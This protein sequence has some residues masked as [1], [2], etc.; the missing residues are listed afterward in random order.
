MLTSSFDLDLIHVPPCLISHFI[1]LLEILF[2]IFHPKFISYRTLRSPTIRSNPSSCIIICFPTHF[3]L[4][5]N[6]NAHTN[7]IVFPDCCSSSELN[8]CCYQDPKFQICCV[9]HFELSM[10]G[11]LGW[12]SILGLF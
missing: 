12:N 5:S 10:L 11:L 8:F 1:D 2:N 6:P 4:S 3:P 9:S 7:P